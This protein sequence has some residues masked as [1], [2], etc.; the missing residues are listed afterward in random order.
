MFAFNL[1]GTHTVHISLLHF[2]SRIVKPCTNTS[3]VFEDITFD[4]KFIFA[5]FLGKYGEG[6]TISL[7]WKNHLRNRIYQVPSNNDH[8][9]IF[10]YHRKEE[11]YSHISYNHIVTIT[12]PNTV[13]LTDTATPIFASRWKK[14]PHECI[15]V[16]ELKFYRRRKPSGIFNGSISNEIQI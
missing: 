6:T 11:L 12:Q 10:I 15:T 13:R 3:L 2:F 16:D 9:Y 4:L 8:F 5:F 14:L 7:I 1:L